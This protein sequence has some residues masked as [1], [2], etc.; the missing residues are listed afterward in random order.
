MKDPIAFLRQCI[1]PFK[2]ELEVWYYH[3]R[4]LWVD[5]KII[6]LT[7]WVILFPKSN[8]TYKAFPTL[9]RKDFEEEVRR[10]E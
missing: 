7:A 8:L 10:W 6:F 2:G 4:S 1:Q 9:P 3:N 5:C